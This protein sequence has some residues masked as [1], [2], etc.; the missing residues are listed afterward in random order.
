LTTTAPHCTFTQQYQ[1]AAA[2]EEALQIIQQ[3]TLICAQLPITLQGQIKGPITNILWNTGATSLDLPDII[4]AGNY[5]LTGT[6]LCGTYSD[7]VQIMVEDWSCKPFVANGFTSNGDGL[8]DRLYTYLSCEYFH[9][10][11]RVYNRWGACVFSSQQANDYWDGTINGKAADVGVY[12]YYMEFLN[13]L[14][15]KQTFKGEVHLIR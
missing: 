15:K 1:V 2:E 11:F 4:A 12:F 3:D 9:Y 14:N 13:K 7:S 8:N 6:G 10:Q 5:F